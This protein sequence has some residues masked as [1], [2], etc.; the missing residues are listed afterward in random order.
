[1]NCVLNPIFIFGLGLGIAGS[2]LATDIAQ[3]VVV[4]WLLAVYLHTKTGLRL[5]ARALRPRPRD[6]ADILSV[7]T[8]P[9][10][11][12]LMTGATLIL[13]NNIVGAYGG[14][15]GI[16]VMGIA[17]SLVNLLLM[18]IV[19]I[20]QGVQP[21]IGYNYGAGAFR[22][23]RSALRVSLIGTVAVCTL[24]YALF[25]LFSREIVGLFVKDSPRI[26][27]LGVL[28]LRIFL[29]STPIVGVAII[30]S[31][32]FQAVKKSATALLINVVRQLIILVPLFVILPRSLGL[33]GVWLACPVS[34]LASVLLTLV[35]LAPEMR[36]LGSGVTEGLQA[37]A[38]S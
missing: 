25:F 24:A 8:A 12:Q 1:M 31:V 3:A 5:H 26:V 7:G 32:Y 37:S 30:G 28:G 36:R 27:T 6:V 19:G 9:C 21:I 34:D 20:R 13:A 29:S 14:D 16:A 4:V 38:A 33:D 11:M 17:T 10:F 23:V 2:A 18:P 15:T 22:R 35:L